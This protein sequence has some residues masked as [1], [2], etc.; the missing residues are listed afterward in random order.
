MLS[1]IVW[2]YYLTQKFGCGGRIR[3][4]DL[5]VMS[6]TSYQTAPPR[7]NYTNGTKIFSISKELKKLILVLCSYASK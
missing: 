5:Q 1:N 2:V 6:L 7:D 4:Y 3:T